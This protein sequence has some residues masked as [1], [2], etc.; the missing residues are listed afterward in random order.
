M[1]DPFDWLNVVI[2]DPPKQPNRTV[3]LIA[4]QE[5][6]AQDVRTAMQG[7][8]QEHLPIEANGYKLT[9]EMVYDVLLK[10]ATENISIDAACRDLE[11]SVDSRLDLQSSIKPSIT[12]SILGIVGS[13]FR[14]IKCC[15]MGESGVLETQKPP[16]IVL[17][18]RQRLLYVVVMGARRPLI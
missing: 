18:D 3:T 2:K 9:N 12:E 1:V 17:L 5:L 15:E 7:V 10:A 13:P 14:E 11:K 16:T 8:V 6:K 4:E